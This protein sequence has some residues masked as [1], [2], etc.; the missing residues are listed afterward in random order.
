MSQYENA[1][2]VHLREHLMK[3]AHQQTLFSILSHSLALSLR[4]LI[5]ST[6]LIFKSRF[7]LYANEV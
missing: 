7:F 2:S 1:L 5:F 4:S 3:L 6:R